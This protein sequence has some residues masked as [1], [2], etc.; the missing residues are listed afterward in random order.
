MGTTSTASHGFTLILRERGFWRKNSGRTASC[1]PVIRICSGYCAIYCA[2]STVQRTF[3][4]C[5]RRIVNGS[6]SSKRRVLKSSTKR[7]FFPPAVNARSKDVFPARCPEKEK[8]AE[9]DSSVRRNPSPL[10][11]SNQ[12]CELLSSSE[13]T[14][15]W[16][17][18]CWE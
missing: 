13:R 3:S 12:V 14:T 11:C 6:P 7:S 9:G 15:A 4:P 1:R 10:F 8:R 16:I 2:T 18:T 5:I 17:F